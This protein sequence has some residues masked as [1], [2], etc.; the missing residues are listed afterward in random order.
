MEKS[1]S[2]ATG[3]QTELGKLLLGV[4]QDSAVTIEKQAHGNEFTFN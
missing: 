4:S 1:A 3:A 2:E